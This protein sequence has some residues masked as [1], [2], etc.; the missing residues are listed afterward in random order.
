MVQPSRFLSFQK[1]DM[2]C[3]DTQIKLFF[4]MKLKHILDS[5]IV[6]EEI[7]KAIDSAVEKYILYNI[8]D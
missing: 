4:Q 7:K 5:N 6:S 1:A 3:K 2:L 8:K